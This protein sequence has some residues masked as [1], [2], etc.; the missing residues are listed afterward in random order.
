[1]KTD[2]IDWANGDDKMIAERGVND[3]LK[4]KGEKCNFTENNNRLMLDYG[5]QK[6]GN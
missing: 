5:K 6:Y 1:M 3:K 4:D 2:F